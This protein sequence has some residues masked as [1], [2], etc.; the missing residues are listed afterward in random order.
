[1]PQS[2]SAIIYQDNTKTT[3]YDTKLTTFSAG[4]AATFNVLSFDYNAGIT[5]ADIC[6]S[7]Q[8]R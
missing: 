5:S 3:I 4:K 6:S 7:V 2:I 1:M 8:L